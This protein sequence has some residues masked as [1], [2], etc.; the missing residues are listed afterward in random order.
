MKKDIN[1][2]FLGGGKRVSLAEHLIKAGKERGVQVNIF[3]YELSREVPIASV[4][5]VIVG[6]KW[7]D[8]SIYKHLPD[9]IRQKNI[10][11]LLPFV[12][13]ATEVAGCLEV[14]VPEVFIPCSSPDLCR[15]MCDKQQADEWFRFEDF[16]IPKSYSEEKK[17]DIVF[18]VILKPFDGSASKGIKVVHDLKS[19]EETPAL[20]TYLIQEYIAENEEYTVDCYVSRSREIISIVPRIRLEVAGGEVMSSRT[21][22]DDVLIQLSAKI[23]ASDDFRGPVTIQFIRNKKDGATYVME[24]NPRLGGGVIASIEAGADIPAFILAESEGESLKPITDW[25][26]NTLMTRYFKE[27]IFYAD[28]H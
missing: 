25:K 3:S 19:L 23:L 4:G 24:I 15:I 21:L 16:P 22:R 18:P 26:E 10:H 28:N 9:I 17:E 1:I 2:L 6:R 13:P 20:D 5:E 7:H 8:V 27:V 12:D 14:L 11:I